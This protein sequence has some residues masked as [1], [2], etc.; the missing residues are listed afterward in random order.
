MVRDELGICLSH[1]MLTENL[2]STFTHIRAYDQESQD[3]DDAHVLLAFPQMTGKEVLCSIR[4]NKTL[5]W[6][7]DYFCPALK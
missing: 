3:P 6:R 5:V 1:E 2:A 7:A 4:G